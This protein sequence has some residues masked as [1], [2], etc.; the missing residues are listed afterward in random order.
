MAKFKD[1][2]KARFHVHQNLS[3]A[4]LRTAEIEVCRLAQ[5]EVFGEEIQLLADGKFLPKSSTIYSLTPILDEDKVLRLAGRIDRAKCV[6]ADTNRPI[7]LPKVHA[8]TT[9]IV[10]HFH[11]RYQ[12]QNQDTICSVIRRKFW[13]PCIRQH[14]RSAKVH[15]QLC[16]NMSAKAKPPLMGQ[17]PE[18]RLIPFIRP[19]SYVGLDYFGPLAVTVGR[20]HEKRWV[21]LFTC[22]SIR[23][24]HIELAKDLSAD[25]TIVCLRNFMNRRG[26]PVRIRSDRGTNFV[27]ASKEELVLID[28]RVADECARRGVEWVF[29]TPANPS[30]GGIWE[31]MVRSVKRVLAFVLKEKAPQAETLISLLIE[32]ENLVNSRPLTHLPLES[33]SAEPLTPN[34]FLLGGPNFVQTPTV[35]EQVC[36]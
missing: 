21:A 25:S 23:A 17:L 35:D 13:I 6:A 27:D 16:K 12:H 22:M 7:I 9:L 1:K 24:I 3:A 36:L 5:R 30:A 4:E 34:H 31:R 28:Q 8:L 33:D 15:C 2:G 29:N 26:V 19:F 20:R 18:D 32:A 14:V 11:E 10:R